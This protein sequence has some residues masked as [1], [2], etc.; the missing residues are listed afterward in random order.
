MFVLQTPFPPDDRSMGYERGTSISKEWEQATTEAAIEV[1]GYVAAHFR[2]LPGLAEESLGHDR[3]DPR[4]SAERFVERAFRRPLTD[5]E[6]ELYID[7]RFRNVPDLET[8]V[9]RVVMLAL[10]SPRFL[11]VSNG[12]DAYDTA[13]RLSLASVGFAARSTLAGSRGRRAAR[14]RRADPRPGPADAG[15]P[16][17]PGQAAAVLPAM[18]EGGIAA[19]P[20]QRSA[21]VRHVRRGDG[22]RSADFADAV[23]RRRDVER[24]IRL[25]PASHGRLRLHERPAGRLLSART[26]RPTPTSRRWSSSRS[27]GRAFCRILT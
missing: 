13:A 5:R 21:G 1:A 14:H 19:R 9:R 3:Q 16:A 2:Q 4:S 12:G 6:R 24:G 15:R 27:S 20:G 25:P 10:V 8:A 22:R 17:G 11:Y 23:P 18:A 26:C 7:R